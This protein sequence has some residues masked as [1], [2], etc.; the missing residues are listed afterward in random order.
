MSKKVYN[1]KSE[2][3]ELVEKRDLQNLR[4][5]EFY[6]YDEYEITDPVEGIKKIYQ[7]LPISAGYPIFVYLGCGATYTA[8]VQK[9]SN[10]YL[11]AI[12]F[13]YSTYK[14][15]YLRKVLEEWY[16]N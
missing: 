4:F 7:N 12:I 6:L 16:V 10:N 14:I 13:G 9:S 15:I 11:S 2:E 5:A 8:I 1:S 3:I